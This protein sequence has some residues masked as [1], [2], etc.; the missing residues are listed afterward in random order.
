MEVSLDFEVDRF[1]KYTAELVRDMDEDF[2]ARVIRTVGLEFIRR[3]I[4]K[5]PVDTGRARAGWTSYLVHLG[6][7][8]EVAGSDPLAKAEG[9]EASLFRESFHVLSEIGGRS[10]RFGLLSRYVLLGLLVA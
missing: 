10:R 6:L 4:L 2:A 1:Q 7:P 5:T 9:L 8:A 3:V